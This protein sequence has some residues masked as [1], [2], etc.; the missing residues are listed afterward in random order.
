MFSYVCYTLFQRECVYVRYSVLLFTLE[1]NALTFQKKLLN[2]F[3]TIVTLEDLKPLIFRREKEERVYNT[4]LLDYLKQI[5]IKN[6]HG[7][8]LLV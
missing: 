3:E 6:E 5:C 2:M 7:Y 8:V 4:F 1:F